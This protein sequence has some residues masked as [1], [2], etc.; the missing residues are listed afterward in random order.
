MPASPARS[1]AAGASLRRRAGAPL[2]MVFGGNDPEKPKL[3]REDEPEEFFASSF[4]DMPAEEKLKDPLVII[5]RAAAPATTAAAARRARGRSD[6]RPRRRDGEGGRARARAETRR[7]ARDGGTRAPRL[8]AAP[9]P[10][11]S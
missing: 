2:R 6:G 8:E 1:L 9:V 5:G 4:E 7:G 11:G 3:T 10:A